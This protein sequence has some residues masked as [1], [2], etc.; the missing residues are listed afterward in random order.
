MVGVKATAPKAAAAPTAPEEPDYESMTNEELHKAAHDRNIEGR[1]SLTTK[2]Q[3][4][5]ALEKDDKAKAKK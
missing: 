4:V 1:G 5:K 3:L 2:D